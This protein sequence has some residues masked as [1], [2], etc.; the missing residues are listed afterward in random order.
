M[1]TG[2]KGASAFNQGNQ[3]KVEHNDSH[4]ALFYLVQEVSKLASP[5]SNTNPP[6]KLLN[7]ASTNNNFLKKEEG[8]E[9]LFQ[10]LHSSCQINFPSAMTYNHL[11][12]VRGDSH[13]GKARTL[14]EQ[15]CESN[16]P[17]KVLSLINLHCERLLHQSDVEELCYSAATSASNVAEG[18][19][20][21]DN[22]DYTS[23]PSLYLCEKQEITASLSPVDDVRGRCA[24]GCC[25]QTGCWKVPEGG[26][27]VYL[28]AAEKTDSVRVEF[29]EEN[30]TASLQPPHREM[31][32]FSDRQLQWNRD[33]LNIPHPENAL[34]QMH[35]VDT[36]L[37]TPLT[38]NPNDK[39]CKDASKPAPTLDHNA[40]ISLSSQSP[41]NTQLSP[42]S[43]ILLSPRLASLLCNTAES[44]SSRSD[45]NRSIGSK[46]DSTHTHVEEKS[47]PVARLKSSNCSVSF[48]ISEPE[49]CTVKKKETDPP[50]ARQWKTKTPRKQPHPSRS[51]DIQDP[52]FQGVT[53]R[54][55]TELDDTREECRLIITSKYSKDLCKSVRKRRQRM[56]ILQKSLKTSSSDEESDL[57]TNVLKGKVCASC[58]T[59]KTPMWRD[60]EDG[61]PLCNACGIRYKKYRVRCV[62]CWHIPRKEGNSNSRCL[63][64]GNFVRLTSAQRKHTT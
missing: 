23:R 2:P 28:Q 47:P 19:F 7:E 10:T 33:V 26:G 16:S 31:V 6:S 5:T 56:R 18:G 43:T 49:L 29:Q 34:Y 20:K 4:S 22:V 45:N 11:K 21:R 37:N 52:D 63:K 58:C 38:F 14:D 46:S 50:S 60:A 55:D 25:K 51:A 8:N 40:N 32:K 57:T 12:N 30:K 53:F 54:M 35:T 15:H 1:S 62:N 17:W 9:H 24:G 64:C 36:C 39:A 27:R 61:T 59:R 13:D 42:P 48:A 3:S 44:S 41:C